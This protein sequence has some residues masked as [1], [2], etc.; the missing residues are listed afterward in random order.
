MANNQNVHKQGDWV[1]K[2]K[3]T[4]E[5]ANRIIRDPNEKKWYDQVFW[6][7]FFLVIFWPVGVVLMFRQ[8]WPWV[9]KILVCVALVFLIWF[10]YTGYIATEQIETDTA[11]EES[12]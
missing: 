7:V 10:S 5:S 2:E 1:H 8:K 6:I 3:R 12:A 4:K 11:S 9:V